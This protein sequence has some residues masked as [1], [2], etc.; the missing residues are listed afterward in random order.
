[1]MVFVSLILFSSIFLRISLTRLFNIPK[2]K[3]SLNWRPGIIVKRTCVFPCWWVLTSLFRR[4][5]LPKA[6]YNTK[7]HYVTDYVKRISLEAPV[8]L[9]SLRSTLFF[10]FFVF[11]T[12]RLLINCVRFKFTLS[13]ILLIQNIVVFYLYRTYFLIRK[14]LNNYPF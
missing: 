1:M 2:T 11:N 14:Y 5:L 7:I 12:Q 4:I 6:S 9:F 10:L 3:V 13:E 8:I